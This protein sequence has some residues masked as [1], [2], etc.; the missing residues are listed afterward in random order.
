M[1]EWKLQLGILAAVLA[2]LLEVAGV[3]AL[4]VGAL[5]MALFSLG[6]RNG[7]PRPHDAGVLL[8]LAGIFL[9]AFGVPAFLAGFL[10]RRW[11]TPRLHRD[12]AV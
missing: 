3:G 4:I 1:S 9:L 12:H 5:C 6:V 8:G 2:S 10:A 7:P 11:L